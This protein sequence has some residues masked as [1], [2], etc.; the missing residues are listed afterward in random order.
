MVRPVD[1]CNFGKNL[2]F[3]RPVDWN[4]P[5][6]RLATEKN[7]IIRP[8]DFYGP[9]GR[10]LEKLEFWVYVRPVDLYGPTG[11]FYWF[12]GNNFKCSGIILK[13]VYRVSKAQ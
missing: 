10:S 4:G 6:G 8:V 13:G 12:W 2:F 9:T 11:R 7:K 1:Y 5:T 3:V